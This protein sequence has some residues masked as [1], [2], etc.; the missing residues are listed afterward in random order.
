MD[1]SKRAEVREREREKYVNL[2]PTNVWLWTLW[3]T[4]TVDE[5]LFS[6]SIA[7]SRAVIVKLYMGSVSRSSACCVTIEPFVI[8]V[9]SLLSSPAVIMYSIFPLWPDWN[10]NFYFSLFRKERKND[11]EKKW[12]FSFGIGEID[13]HFKLVF[14]VCQCNKLTKKWKFPWYFHF[15]SVGLLNNCT[16]IKKNNKKN[17]QENLLPESISVALTAT[18]SFPIGIFSNTSFE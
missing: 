9:K 10:S 13:C 12:F 4:W 11:N 15:L 18:T 17:E 6:G 1:K 5:S 8:I 7:Q 16:E 14:V 3:L 2:P